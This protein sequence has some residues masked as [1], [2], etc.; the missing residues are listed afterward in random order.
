MVFLV[1]IV[2]VVV[3]IIVVAYAVLSCGNKRQL[4]VYLVGVVG[5]A[6]S[7]SCQTQPLC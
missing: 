1:A 7:F 6:K 2:V 5:Y 3:L 4:E